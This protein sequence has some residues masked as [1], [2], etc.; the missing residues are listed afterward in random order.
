MDSTSVNI[1]KKT[2]RLKKLKIGIPREYFAVGLD[3]E[4]EKSINEA[5]ETYKKLG[6]EIVDIILPHAGYALACYYIIAPA[7]ASANLARFDG[8]RYG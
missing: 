6:A 4:V 3:E 8:L 7:E 2:A 1:S 5:I